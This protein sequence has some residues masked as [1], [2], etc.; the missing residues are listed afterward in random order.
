MYKI[1]ISLILW[2]ILMSI[3]IFFPK[4]E[5]IGNSG[6]VANCGR[7]FVFYDL[8]KYIYPPPKF[9]EDISMRPNLPLLFIEFISVSFLCLIVFF[10]I[11]QKTIFNKYRAIK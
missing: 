4:W 7:A 10:V 8:T 5:V 9:C 3:F 6:I 2:I 1:K 11:N